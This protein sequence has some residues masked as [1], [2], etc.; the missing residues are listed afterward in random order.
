MRDNEPGRPI[1]TAGA[2]IYEV[3]LRVD[4]D[5]LGEFDPWLRSHVEQM[6]ALE[7]FESAAIDVPEQTGGNHAVRIV[8]YRLASRAALDHYLATH[9]AR[10]RADGIERFGERFSATRAIYPADGDRFV[11][12][13]Q[14]CRNCDQ[15]L[16]G[17]YCAVC[18]QRVK[19][20]I[21]S[22]WELL[23]DVVGDVFEL[24]SRLW[25]TLL[26][27]LFRPGRLTVEYLRGRRVHYTP[28]FR[29]YLVTSLIFFLVAFFG[30][31]E[32]GLSLSVDDEASGV[33]TPA[34][35]DAPLPGVADDASSTAPVTPS[36]EAAAEKSGEDFDPC[37][38]I[39]IGD[40]A[41]ENA[42][43]QTARSACEQERNEAGGAERDEDLDF[44][45]VTC[46][47]IDLDG[48]GFA[49]ALET[50]ARRA[51]ERLTA[52]GG[53]Q[54]FVADLVDNLPGMMFFFLPV[55]AL[56]MKLL[57]PLS[58]RYYV[59]HLL[60]FLHFHAFFF[61]LATLTL[62]LSRV[63]AAV[64]GQDVAA[65]LTTLVAVFY[66]PAYLYVAQRR[67]YG[68]GR[69]LTFMKFVLLLSAYFVSLLLLVVLV[70][71]FT[72]LSL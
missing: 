23:R 5:A 2:V 1:L 70:M 35:A 42:L 38:Q 18:G 15:P 48:S 57:Y 9:A 32:T 11:A 45:S 17:Q 44:S 59:E 13:A 19:H 16:S 33:E 14:R 43:E 66:T 71:L 37:E 69:L 72:A 47:N 22:L 39:E 20:R 3:R 68:Q 12:A 64:P 6:L 54:R 60:F 7:G 41:W 55:I 10:L 40:S 30:S 51:C 21:I 24:D 67:V 26:P 65:T 61:V 28:P 62:L 8:R 56:V 31:G 27:L 63:P 50:R 29:L 46:A 49:Q 25:R 36:A 58:R 4:H 53:V 52:K 34:E